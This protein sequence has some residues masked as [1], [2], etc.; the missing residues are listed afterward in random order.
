MFYPGEIWADTDGHHIQAHGGGVLF[1][2]GTYYWYGENRA[3]PNEHSGRVGVVGVSCYSS[4]EV[5]AL[6]R[7]T[8]SS[9]RTSMLLRDTS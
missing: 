9:R 4:Q 6:I 1:D 8:I 5:L 2:G 7:S 3:A